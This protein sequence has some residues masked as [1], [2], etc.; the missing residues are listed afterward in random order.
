MI[1]FI[2][3]GEYIKIGFTEDDDAEKRLNA[4]Q[5][6]NARELRLIGVIPGDKSVERILHNVLGSLRARG[7]WFRISDHVVSTEQP[8]LL[9]PVLAAYVEQVARGVVP[10]G[11]FT[12]E[13]GVGESS[14]KRANSIF[15]GR[16]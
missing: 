9:P 5:T 13:Y 10:D 16:R 15:L 1:Y 12:A 8:R 3:D 2:S 6:G 11:D 7:E 14:L 4:L